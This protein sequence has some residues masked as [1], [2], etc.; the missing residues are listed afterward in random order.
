METTVV[1]SSGQ[2]Y[3]MVVMSVIEIC[4][5]GSSFGCYAGKSTSWKEREGHPGIR[6]R[7]RLAML[8]DT[9]SSSGHVEETANPKAVT[10]TMVLRGAAGTAFIVIAESVKRPRRRAVLFVYEEC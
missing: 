3:A 4:R 2:F 1:Y 9:N 6:S 7:D 5:C 10:K 8:P